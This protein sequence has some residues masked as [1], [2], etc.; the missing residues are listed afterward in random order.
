MRGQIR[1]VDKLVCVSVEPALWRERG[2]IQV[3][4]PVAALAGL[5]EHDGLVEALSIR[6]GEGHRRG[7]GAAWGA[8]AVVPTHTAVVRSVET[9]TAAACVVET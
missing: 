7:A 9:S 4:T 6:A 8:A 1:L 2:F 3:I 5:D